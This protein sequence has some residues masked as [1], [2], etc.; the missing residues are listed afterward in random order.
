MSIRLSKFTISIS[1]ENIIV[2]YSTMN[3]IFIK[4]S[5]YAMLLNLLIGDI[6][7]HRN[8]KTPKNVM[9]TFLFI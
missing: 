3:F 2:T 5:Y 9:P 8:S 4:I 1:N 6:N 7:T